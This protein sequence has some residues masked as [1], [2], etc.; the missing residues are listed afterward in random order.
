MASISP[1]SVQCSDE[2][3]TSKNAYLKLTITSISD[4]DA[5]TNE[6]YI[7]WKLTVEGTPWVALYAYSA[8]LGGVSLTENLDA[9]VTGWS[10]GQTIKSGT[11]TYSNDSAGNLTLTAYVKQLFY[12]YYS[13][14]RWSSVP[15]KAQEASVNM[16]CSQLPR[17][18]NL[19]KYEIGSTE[20]NKFTIN[21]NAD[22]TCDSVQY[23]LNGGSWTNTS[24]LSFSIGGLTPGQQ[25]NIRIRVKRTDSQLWT[26]SGYLYPTCKSLPTTNTPSNFNIGSNLTASISSTS[27]L[28]KWFCDID[29][30]STKIGSSGDVT[31]TSKTVTLTDSTMITNMLSRHSSANDWNI[32]VK[33]Y[34]VSNGTQYTLTERTCKCVIPSSSYLPTFNESNVSYVVT[35]STTNNLTGSNKKVIKG[36]SDIQVTC[37]QASPQGGATISKYTATSGTV[38]NTTT[39]TSSPVMNLTNVTANSVSV[40]VIDS[41]NKSKSVTK[42]YDAFIDYFAPTLSSATI[43]RVDGVGAN[44]NVSL[45]GKY[46]NW[47]GLSTT[48]VMQQVSLQYKLKG[49]SQYTTIS[50]VNLTITNNNGNFTATGLITGDLFNTAN[51]YDLLIT[52][53]DKLNNLTYLYSIPTGQALLW[54]DMANSRIGIGKKP[55]YTLDIKGT[56]HVSG[57]FKQEGN[58]SW[59]GARDYCSINNSKGDAS[60]SYSA[61]VGQKT[62]DG[63]WTIGRLNENA[64]NLEFVYTTDANY[65]GGT[66]T[67]SG[68]VKLSPHTGTIL[69]T[70]N[71]LNTVYPVGS[72]YISGSPTNPGNIFG[73]TW[74]QL[75]NRFLFATNATSGNK[76]KDAPGTH[77]GTNTTSVTL[78]AAQSGVPAHGHGA[79]GSYSGANF[80]IRHGSSSGTE[81]VAA[82]TNTTITNQAYSSNWGNGFGVASYSHKPDRVNIGGTVSVTVNNNSAAN[83]SSGHSHGV[84]Y[85]EVYVWQRTA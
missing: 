65:N 2:P 24:G 38:T 7:G 63:H 84:S 75:K 83:A 48:N 60:G 67:Q 8:S 21:W 49:A 85:I 59:I 4:S 54:R 30:G 56:A 16:V 10:A 23:S 71:W 73:G 37:T 41:R 77:T 52:L 53:K 32:T 82:G 62:K 42:S 47:S 58:G 11:K 35:D 31:T 80:Y 76:G 68:R 40:Q 14:S 74:T 13:A 36:V 1:T 25:Y 46:C 33:Y 39:N 19:T 12:L 51:E 22:A 6:R 57:Q 5:S 66:N 55:S 43:A 3:H 34:C 64:N 20:I 70:G 17:Y 44:I 61:V 15:S 45:A 69:T 28:S 29:D 9:S 18:A 78:T 72:I 79:S 26:T 50:G 27:Y 81:S